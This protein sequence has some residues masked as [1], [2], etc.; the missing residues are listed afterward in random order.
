MKIIG[1]A[2]RKVKNIRN[3]MKEAWDKKEEIT[4]EI[5]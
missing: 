1:A 5:K 4:I 2:I 3:K